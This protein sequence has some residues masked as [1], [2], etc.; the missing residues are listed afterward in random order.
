MCGGTRITRREFIEGIALTAAGLSLGACTAGQERIA[1]RTFGRTKH[2]S[3]RVI[4]GSYAFSR[5]LEK[6][7]VEQTFG[8]LQ[9]Y[10]INH[11]D[12]AP[13]YGGAHI[14][15][16]AWMKEHRDQY[17]L[18][19]KTDQRTYAAAK[20]QI[21]QSLRD[22]QSDY[23]DLLQLH[24]LVDPSEWEIAMGDDGALKAVLEAQRQGL[25]RF[26]GV[27]GHGVTAPAMHL[28]SLERYD[29]DSVLLPLNYPLFQNSRY[30][31]DFE[32]L[33][34]VCA[35]RQVAVQIIKAIAHGGSYAG[36]SKRYNTWYRPLEEQDAIDKAVHWVLGRSELFLISAGDIELLPKILDAASRFQRAPTDAE[37][38]QLVQEQGMKP[39]FT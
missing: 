21:E 13:S 27:T 31:D 33:L 15:L 16:G 39:L 4:F 9:E 23:V 30:A 17:F 32:A 11:I 14:W 12:T 28:K 20:R 6:E 25:T 36:A 18:A 10:G 34:E 29:F 8:V 5:V 19:T 35:Q 1:K 24:N 7:K 22:L 2:R 26:V 37:M 38:V 3:T